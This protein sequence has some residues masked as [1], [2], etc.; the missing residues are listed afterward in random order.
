M[1]ART[2]HASMHSV[3][4]STTRPE[5][6]PDCPHPQPYGNRM[7]HIKSRKHAAGRAR[8]GAA[9]VTTSLA[10]SLALALPAFAADA[11]D[12]AAPEGQLPTVHVEGHRIDEYKADEVAS[13]KFVKPLVDTTQSIQIITGDL[14]QSQGATT[15]TEALRN[16]AGVGTF[17]VGENGNTTTGDAIYMRGFDSSS[18]IFV[19]GARDL[20]SISRD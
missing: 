16:S 8:A 6:E 12:E 17:Y 19:D 13:P 2:S 20:G 18:S 10:T 1:S 3:S 5:R 11:A 15:L 4:A 14:I 7:N 9:M